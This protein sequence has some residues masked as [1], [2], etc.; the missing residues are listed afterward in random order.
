MIN[1]DFLLLQAIGIVIVVM[2]HMGIEF[3]WGIFQAYSFHMPLFIFISGYF[4][5]K[6]SEDNIF[7]YIYKKI[8]RLIV[9][10]FF[11]NLIYGILINI[12]KRMEW[13]NYGEK[14]N[15]KSL[16]EYPIINGHQFGLNVAGW[17][18][19]AL[20]I[21]QITYVITRRIFTLINVKNE[22]LIMSIFF[23]IGIIGVYLGNKGYIEGVKIVFTRTLF[24]ISFYNMGYFYKEKIENRFKYNNIAFF[25]I[26]LSIQFI[27]IKKY[28]NLAFSAVWC[29]EFNKE[30]IF[31]PHIASITGILFWLKISKI[32]SGFI[33]NNRYIRY[34]GQNTWTVMMHHQFI[35]FII[36]LNL[37]FINKKI[38]LDGFDV[39]QF[40]SNGWYSYDFG[41]CRFLTLYVIAGVCIPLLCKKYFDNILKRRK[42]IDN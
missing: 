27:M 39:E 22:Y 41:D 20:F 1:Y 28:K 34:I 37:F 10:Y 26:L 19:I 38:A 17:F 12:F 3:F 24:L 29:N 5:N 8:R 7:K 14:V 18:V 31:L 16:V 11:I 6:K 13:V 23:I 42:V 32:F 25:I 15:F 4:Y 30:N 40:K 36:N 9:P 2:G 35:F 21:V 33:K